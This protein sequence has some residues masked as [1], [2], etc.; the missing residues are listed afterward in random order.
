[1]FLQKQVERA[2]KEGYKCIQAK[3]ISDPVAA[4]DLVK[5][6]VPMLEK[7][8]IF[9]VDANTCKDFPLTVHPI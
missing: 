4:A 7:D 3:I 1:M 9:L 5:E 8:T 6:V 2:V